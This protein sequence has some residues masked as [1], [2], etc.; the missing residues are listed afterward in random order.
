MKC[1][2]SYHYIFSKKRKFMVKYSPTLL[3]SSIFF[4]L[5]FFGSLCNLWHH[6]PFNT[7]TSLVFQAFLSSYWLIFGG[8]S[9]KGPACQ[10]SRPKRC[11]FDPWVGK[12]PWRRKWQ[13]TPVFSPGEFHREG[14]LE[15]YS[16]WGRKSQTQLKRLSAA[17]PSE[18]DS[19]SHFFFWLSVSSH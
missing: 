13:P 12:I 5:I 14:R 16:A 17:Q 18:Q 15:G 4:L 3:R 9:G 11:R 2:F 10:C 8:T 6:R 7:Q 1:H 19:L